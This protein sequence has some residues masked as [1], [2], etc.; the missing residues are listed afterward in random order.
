ML[1][2][3]TEE[4]L[5][6]NAWER[7]IR[8]KDRS[9][10]PFGRIVSRFLAARDHRGTVVADM[11]PGHYDFGRALAPL[12]AKVVGLELDPAVIALGKHRGVD[13]IEFDL[14]SRMLG[15]DL[16]RARWD[17]VFCNGSIN[18][19]WQRGPGAQE[20]YVADLKSAIKPGGWAYIAPCNYAP[21]Q[22]AD[23][24]ARN[25]EAVEAI[26]AQRAA[27]VRAGFTVWRF[28]RFQRWRYAMSTDMRPA[29][30]YTLNLDVTRGP[31]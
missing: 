26:E 29:Y 6:A 1:V 17:G 15:A 2:D 5:V 12:G 4:R 11:G 27:F 13:V 19:W 20:A 21:E 16:G 24:A 7:G 22:N 30:V 23:Q 14:R 10:K 28:N 18:C 31:W 9:A 8:R 3:E 25:P